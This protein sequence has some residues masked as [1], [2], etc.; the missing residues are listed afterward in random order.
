[1]L[2]HAARTRANLLRVVELERRELQLQIQ[3]AFCLEKQKA[4]RENAPFKLKMS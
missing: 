1:M 2:A 3:A 4:E